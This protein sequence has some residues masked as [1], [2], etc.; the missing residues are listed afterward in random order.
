MN[1]FF[2]FNKIVD[3]QIQ[4]IPVQLTGINV[5]ITKINSWGSGYNGNIT[6]TSRDKDIG[7]WKLTCRSNSSITW[8]SGV[9]YTFTNGI[10]ELTPERWFEQIKKNTT[11]TFDFGSVTDL[12]FVSLVEIE[13]SIPSESVN[14]SGVAQQPITFNT[15]TTEINKRRLKIKLN[16]QLIIRTSE[17]ITDVFWN[18]HKVF[19]VIKSSI[20][21]VTISSI[22]SGRGC[23]KV[24]SANGERYIGIISGTGIDPT[25]IPI[26]MVSEDDPM[27]SISFW[28]DF[29]KE[30]EN[31]R[32]EGR[33]IYINGGPGD[34]GWKLNYSTSEWN[35]EVLGKRALNFIRNSQILGMVPTLVYYNI[36]A[37]NESYPTNNE[38]LQ[39]AS[40]MNSYFKDL[41]FLLDMI[42][43][44]NPDDLTR[45][46]L[47]PDSIGYQMQNSGKKLSDILVR[48]DS[49]KTSGV[50]TETDPDF[51][52]TNA[53]LIQAINYL[54]HKKCPQVEF[55]WQ[56]NAWSNPV[57]IPGGIGI[58]KSS[59]FIPNFEQAKTFIKKTAEDTAKYYL[60]GGI[61]SHGASFFSIDKYGLEWSLTTADK[62]PIPNAWAFQSDHWN[63]YLLYAKSLGD[64]IK[65]PCVLWQLP[66]GRLNGSH[67]ISPYTGQR[68]PDMND[69]STKGQD[70]TTTFFFGDTF[71]PPLEY[72]NYWAQNK[73]GD[74]LLT[75]DG[76]NIT[77]G[78]HLET[79]KNYGITHYMCGA[80]VGNSTNSSGNPISGVTP[81]DNYFLISKI[82]DSY[83]K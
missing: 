9:K 40:Y 26:S 72:Y 56:I 11:I 34:Y 23:L 49:I 57:S 25:E 21:E 47:E 58:C 73:W 24:K 63:N 33:Y 68:F 45:I 32:C 60:E 29:E 14:G 53:G 71:T 51:S 65:L 1:I 74:P 52:N 81:S 5:N 16:T 20:T 12:T 2:T 83:K 10:V 42:N 41:D 39:S 48:V 3:E 6:I 8:A 22:K 66:V 69:T 28:K 4:P 17:D 70:S 79:L 54:I 59:D 75:T 80:G 18:N 13:P 7:N 61:I 46:I 50:L 64:I 27:T 62:N 19:N 31:K 15:D 82:Q 67:Y 55:G 37:G 44:E 38:N 76:T 78:S 30:S 43:K 77:Y 35:L 36:P